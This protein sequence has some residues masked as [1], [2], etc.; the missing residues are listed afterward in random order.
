MKK[1]KK[2]V[3]IKYGKLTFRLPILRKTRLQISTNYCFFYCISNLA[4][5]HEN[6]QEGYVFPVIFFLVA[7]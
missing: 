6:S 5:C 2:K 4:N 3:N 1:K 7:L